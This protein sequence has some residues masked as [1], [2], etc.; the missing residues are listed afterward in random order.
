MTNNATALE[1]PIYLDYAATTPV[2]P[3]VIKKMIPFLGQA[4]G[5][6]GNASSTLHPFGQRA[7]QAITEA[8][9]AVASLLN[10]QSK[11]IY[12]TSG[13]TES[14]NLALKGAAL[15]YKR[16]GN[17]IVT[18][19]TEH[20]VVLDTCAYL[21]EQGFEITYLKPDKQGLIEV[22]HFKAALKPN[23]ILVSLLQ[24]NNETGV[25]QDIATLSRIT[26][27]RGILF[28]VDAA[29][30]V[31][32][33]PIDLQNLPV[34]L[35]SFSAHK[36]YGPKGVGALYLNDNP[37]V[38]LIPQLQGGGQEQ[39]IRPGTLPTHQ[40]VGMGEAFRLA[41]A[42][43]SLESKRRVSL[44]DRF[45]Q[46]IADLPGIALNGHPTAR[47]P[48]ILNIRFAGIEK[49]A[50]LAR[51]SGLAI[52]AAAACAASSRDSSHVLQAMGLTS[53]WAQQSLRFSIGRFTTTA[54]IDTAVHL[55]RQAF[56]ADSAY[57]LRE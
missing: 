11:N 6:Y 33:I 21:A 55:I 52:S 38:R 54:D 28:H 29:Q 22:D 18:C 47:V 35:M 41:E 2:D 25:I 7:A 19:Q 10:T 9:E 8:R 43:F 53:E 51:L 57:T 15:F 17:H 20:R 36:V 13:A 48:E 50:F 12:W 32:K 24:V 3:R 46:G 4:A 44:K 23:T 34:D 1:P 45:W 30:S 26:R 37:R 40:I 39:G 5:C 49:T 27:E 31:G 42:E 56:A 16:R 14:I